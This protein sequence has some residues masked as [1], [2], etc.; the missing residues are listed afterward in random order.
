MNW[1][2]K[3]LSS[4]LG[5]KLIMS[6]TGLFLI[7]FLVV[8][9]VGNLAIFKADEGLAFNAYAVLMTSNP[10]IKLVS[11]G[12]YLSIL[13]HALYGLLLTLHNRKARPVSYAVVSAAANSSWASRNMMILGTLVFAFIVM[14]LKDFWWHYKFSGY[15]FAIDAEGNRDLYA[16]VIE[17]FR[18]PF[19]LVSYLIGLVALGIHLSHG[20][21][22]AFQTLGLEHSKYTPFIK[23]LGAVFSVVVPAGFAA[24]PL[25]VYF[26]M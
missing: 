13:L 7:L 6:L 22:S 4:S 17:Q 24:M 20:F 26:F 8:H 23:K 9:L 14:H 11:Y 10:L 5:K 2:T 12:L 3:S 15:E 18:M 16:L 19:S 1:L 25:Y 21:Q